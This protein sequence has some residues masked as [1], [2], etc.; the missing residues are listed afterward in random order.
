ML[1]RD[2]TALTET[3]AHNEAYMPHEHAS[4]HPVDASLEYSRPLR[5]L[6][7]WL[8]FKTH[9]AEAFREAIAGT[10]DLARAAYERARLVPGFRTLDTPPQLSVVPLAHVPSDVV[11]ADDHQRRLCRAINR[12]GRVFLSTAM[13][14]GRTWLRPCFTNFRTQPS[15]VEALFDV[16]VEQS[17]RIVKDRPA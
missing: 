4:P 1:V 5:A 8:A 9:G 12:D 15:D 14:D 2:P 6:K 3:F 17:S 7:L 10:I 11:D 16:I 13:I